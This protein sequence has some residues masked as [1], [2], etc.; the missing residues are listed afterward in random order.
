MTKADPRRLTAAAVI[1]R[2]R[3]GESIRQVARATRR[4]YAGVHRILAQH[5]TE[6]RPRGGANRKAHS[7][8]GSEAG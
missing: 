1:R 3:R 4:S 5:G 7:E 6:F 8:A 2:Y